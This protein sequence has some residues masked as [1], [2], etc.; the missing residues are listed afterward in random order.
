MKKKNIIIGLVSLVV[1]AGLITTICVIVH[2]NNTKLDRKLSKLATEYYEGEPK[3]Y[4]SDIISH[5]GYF[6]V[7]LND[8]KGMDMDISLFEKYSCD[9]TDT[10][11]KFTFEKDKSYK[12]ET[13]LACQEK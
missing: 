1:L 3:E 11:A 2:L 4:A 10:Y 12:I 6:M 7:S 8:L 5:L 13:H 9:L